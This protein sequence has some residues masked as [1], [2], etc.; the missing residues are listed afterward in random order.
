MNK[1]SSKNIKNKKISIIGYGISG[2]SATKLALHLGAKVFISDK[3]IIN[4]DNRFNEN[5]SFEEGEH[6]SK[7]YDCDFAIISPGIN[8]NN[9]FFEKFKKNNIPIISEIEFASWFTK[10]TIIAITGSNGK[11]TTVSLL[12]HMLKDY[13]KTYLG[14][15]IGIPFSSSVLDEMKNNV[16]NSIHILELS[17]FQLEHIYDFKPKVACILNLSNDH[18]DR[19]LTLE[20]YY[21]AKKNIL[22]NMDEHSYFI[23]N[24]NN[25][26]LYKNDVINKA[27]SISFSTNNDNGNYYLNNHFIIDKNTNKKIIDCS[28][29][30]LLGSHNIENILASIEILKVLE[31]SN[32]ELIKSIYNFSPLQHRMEKISTNNNIT[33]IND[34]KATN[35]DSAI[36][37]I[38][39][40]EDDTILI[41]GGYSKGEIDYKKIFI[42]HDL[43]NIQHIVCYG[44]EGKTIYKQL[45]NI[46]NCLYINNFEEAII[47]AI[48]LAKSNYRVLLSPACSS[49]DQFNNFE[50]RG[51]KFKT[52]VKQYS[53]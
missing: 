43:S 19:Y 6:S 30:Q 44:S 31:L 22:K 38:S 39:C 36:R 42:N 3:E 48:K 41:L 20:E 28:K 50:D 33:F 24:S 13:K 2:I 34:S 7:C 4:K 18:L 27:N 17:S 51:N 37:A 21:N 25:K 35:P 5:I 11:S 10:S 14:G 52:I 12:Y 53:A 49:F 26:F 40:S 32:E 47:N 29:I 46:F 8:T 15:N 23:Y 1:I 45:K 9:I 16:T